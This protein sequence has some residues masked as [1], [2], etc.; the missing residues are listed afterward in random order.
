MRFVVSGVGWWVSR[1][2]FLFWMGGGGAER[3]YATLCLVAKG[4]CVALRSAVALRA[5][6]RVL[7]PLLPEGATVWQPPA[8][9]EG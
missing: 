7:A 2:I 6:W 8:A 4:L 9:K 3:F 1:P 5:L